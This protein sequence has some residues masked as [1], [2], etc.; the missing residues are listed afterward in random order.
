MCSTSEPAGHPPPAARRPVCLEVRDLVLGYGERVV[1]E[2]VSFS[3]HRSEIFIVMGQS[4]CGKSTLLRSL[5]GLL[6][7]MSGDILLAGK[8][9]WKLD[10]PSRQALL[11]RTGVAF[12]SG[13]LWS[14]LTL[15]EN[16]AL[17]LRRF[18]PLAASEV[19]TLVAYKLA[20]V[21]LSGHEAAYPHE[22]S[23][24]MRKRAAIARA[25]ALDPEILFLDEP[26]AGLDPVNAR[27]ID[28]LL[29]ELRASLGA[30]ML[31]VTHELQSIFGIADRCLYLDAESRTSLAVGPP[32]VLRESGP[33]P[34]RRFLHGGRE[35]AGGKRE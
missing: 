22:L 20:L 23:G 24:G 35:P 21:G 32:A 17:P 25:L 11:R 2:R 30:T 33:L 1:L 8:S 4:G 9:L 3:V 6:P 15:F 28:D 13:A 12:Q 19:E 27:H 10:P 18:T 26:S 34:V 5:I 31:V 16:V 7:P 14:S 29:L